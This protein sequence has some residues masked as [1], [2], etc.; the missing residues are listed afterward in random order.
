MGFNELLVYYSPYKLLDKWFEI[1]KQKP[2]RKRIISFANGVN[3]NNK[4]NE[5]NKCVAN[6]TE[7]KTDRQTHSKTFIGFTHHALNNTQDNL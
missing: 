6:K 7:R 3:N 4:D 1:T 2:S 5:Y